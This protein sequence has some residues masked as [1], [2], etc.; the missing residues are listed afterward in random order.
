M[1]IS[2]HG[3]TAAVLVMLAALFAFAYSLAKGAPIGVIAFT[4]VYLLSVTITVVRYWRARRSE[5][6][7]SRPGTIP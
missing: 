1:S 4:T 5:D 6:S 3:R 7:R 2:W